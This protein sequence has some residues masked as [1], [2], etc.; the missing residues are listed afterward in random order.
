LSRKLRDRPNI[1]DDQVLVGG[2]TH[3]IVRASRRPLTYSLCVAD[4]ERLALFFFMGAEDVPC[5]RL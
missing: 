3:T 4:L 5:L 1:E 2:V